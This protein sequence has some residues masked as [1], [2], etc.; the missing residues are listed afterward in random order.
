MELGGVR[1]LSVQYNGLRS[2]INVSKCGHNVTGALSG[3]RFRDCEVGGSNPLAPTNQFKH[4][5]AAPAARSRF[6]SSNASACLFH[7]CKQT[8]VFSLRLAPRRERGVY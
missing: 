5:W 4:L 6:G 8:L 1:R 3:C 2:S 7:I